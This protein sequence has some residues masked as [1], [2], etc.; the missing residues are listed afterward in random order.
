MGGDG[1]GK[2]R[3]MG[4]RG[5]EE[6]GEGMKLCG[7]EIVQRELSGIVFDCF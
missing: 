4:R 7:E 2:K 1:F 6:E 5:S 3:V